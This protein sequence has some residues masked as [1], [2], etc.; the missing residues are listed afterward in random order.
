MNVYLSSFSLFF[1]TYITRTLCE[2]AIEEARQ[3]EDAFPDTRLSF[4]ITS[5]RQT[6]A[7]T[8]LKAAR[9]RVAR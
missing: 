6:G 4:P 9:R 1:F 3:R 5:G 7:T 8:R 2:D